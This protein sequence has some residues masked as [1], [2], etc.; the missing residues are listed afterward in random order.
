MKPLR[1]SL[2]CNKHFVLDVKISELRGDIR[3][4]HGSASFLTSCFFLSLSLWFAQNWGSYPIWCRSHLL[5]QETGLET[6][7]WLFSIEGE[8]DPEPLC[9]VP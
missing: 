4:K 8:V 2:T 9:G 5:L 7:L 1:W 3:A 6:T